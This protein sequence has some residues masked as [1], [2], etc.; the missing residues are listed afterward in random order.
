MIGG[1]DPAGLGGPRMPRMSWSVPVRRVR[2]VN[3]MASSVASAALR[4]VRQWPDPDARRACHVYENAQACATAPF[5]CSGRMSRSP[6]WSA[7]GVKT[8]RGGRLSESTAEPS[9][10]VADWVDARRRQAHPTSCP[11]AI[12]GSGTSTS[13]GTSGPPTASMRTARI[14]GL[15]SSAIRHRRVE[16]TDPSRAAPPRWRPRPNDLAAVAVPSAL[17]TPAGSFARAA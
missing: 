2:A 13:T 5:D 7:D 4:L 1:D 3:S 16:D 12:R 15:H 10:Q 6:L 11:P 8:K 17:A 14:S 9:W